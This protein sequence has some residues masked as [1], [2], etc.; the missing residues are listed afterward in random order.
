MLGQSWAQLF[1][2]LKGDLSQDI[3]RGLHL[4][5]ALI[6]HVLEG[7]APCSVKALVS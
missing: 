3:N 7:S 1:T 4:A 5:G 2:S 6:E